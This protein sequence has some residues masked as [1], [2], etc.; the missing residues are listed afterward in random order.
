MQYKMELLGR[1]LIERLEEEDTDAYNKLERFLE[2]FK[3]E[4]ASKLK[5]TAI[6]QCAALYL[7]FYS[8]RFAD[9]YSRLAFSALQQNLKEEALQHLEKVGFYLQKL[10]NSR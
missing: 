1:E 8:Q 4:E 2:E 9:K 6:F 5:N 3:S 7:R 10:S